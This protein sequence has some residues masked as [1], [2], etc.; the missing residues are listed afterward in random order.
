MKL[1][2]VVGVEAA[3]LIVVATSKTRRK[4]DDVRS[5]LIEEEC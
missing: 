5:G 4:S 3:S 1:V 2:V